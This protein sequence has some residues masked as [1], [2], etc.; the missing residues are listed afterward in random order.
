MIKVEFQLLNLQPPP[1]FSATPHMEVDARKANEQAAQFE[2]REEHA[3]G[4][5]CN[6][7]RGTIGDQLHIVIYGWSSGKYSP[8]RGKKKKKGLE[9]L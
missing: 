4:K 9:D 1:L 6:R 5:T 3:R 8:F 2:V 7:R